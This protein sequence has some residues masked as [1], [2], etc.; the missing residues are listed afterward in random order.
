[1]CSLWW[2]GPVAKTWNICMTTPKSMGMAAR[3]RCTSRTWITTGAW[4]FEQ[5]PPNGPLGR[6]H[7]GKD[8]YNTAFACPWKRI[9][10]C[11]VPCTPSE[12]TPL[13]NG[14][15]IGREQRPLGYG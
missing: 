9:Q 7:H 3:R 4:T 15:N 13:T 2:Y 10:V 12:V 8:L 11:H 5:M 14:V 6:T 1:M